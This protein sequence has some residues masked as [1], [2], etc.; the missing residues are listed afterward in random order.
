MRSLRRSGSALAVTF[1]LLLLA[2]CGGGGELPEP[3]RPAMVV[4]P[5]AA[6]IAV[7]SF[8]GEVR[9]RREPALAFQVGG[10][11]K[12]RAVEVGDRVR[13]GQVLA[14][15]DPEDLGLQVEAARA[16][17]AAAEADLA[18]ARA[19]RDRYQALVEQQV[20]SRSLFETRQ[21][22]WQAAEA[23]ARQTRAQLAV[24][25]NQA[26][27]A[28]L[29]A[30]AD[31]RIAQR[32]AE[33]GQV[34]GAG[35]AV[36]VLAEDGER[37]VAISLPEQRIERFTPGLPVQVELWSHPGELI[38]GRLREIAPAADP[39]SRTYAARIGLQ[40]ARIPA[41]LGQSA[42]VHVA[43]N[44]RQ[45]L[46]LPLSAIHANGGEPFVWVVEPGTGLAL[47]RPVQL[48]PY[49]EERVPVLSGLDKGEWVVAAGVH[50][51]REGQ[52]LRPVDR[53]NRPVDLAA[54]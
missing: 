12:A 34:V 28:K 15:L 39:A 10:R 18:L 47:K 54:R 31:G 23:R 33:V 2:A 49:G 4:Q 44:G 3:V 17:L 13:R 16:Q 8:A 24:A 36:F 53:D 29:T 50:L 14:E 48:G 27:Y 26:G 45:A 1:S 25:Q 37:E 30:P 22:A 43:F 51:V 46:A 6:D 38:Q 32:L 20:V 7:E 42:R 41:D 5:V 9:A 11:L 40:E 52:R 19:E 21:S 35:Q